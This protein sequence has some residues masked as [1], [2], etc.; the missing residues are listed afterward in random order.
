VQLRTRSL[1]GVLSATAVIALVLVI[2]LP[3]QS[4]DRP[5]FGTIPDFVF[6]QGMP[7]HESVLSDYIGVADPNGPGIIGYI[8]A[9]YAW[10]VIGAEDEFGSEDA[11]PVVDRDLNVIG[12]MVPAKGFVPLGTSFEDAPAIPVTTTH[13]SADTTLP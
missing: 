6:A 2:A 1:V 9:S 7:V 13:G 11:R 10:P 5:S 12:H 8:K 3:S 4:A